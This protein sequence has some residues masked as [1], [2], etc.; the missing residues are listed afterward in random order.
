[1]QLTVNGD[2]HTT[3]ATTVADLLRELGLDGRPCAVEINRELAPKR[4]HTQRSLS[5][6]DRVEIVTLVGGG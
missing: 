3:Q 6:N 5:E 1:M 4:E 2:P